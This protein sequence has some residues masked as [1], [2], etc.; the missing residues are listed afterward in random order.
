MS[1]ALIEVRVP[2]AS[3]CDYFSKIFQATQ[4]SKL[5]LRKTLHEDIP[6]RARGFTA[7]PN[8]DLARGVPL[9]YTMSQ[10]GFRF[11]R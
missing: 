3:N 7:Q 9:L 10:M 5:P 1:S 11:T 4:V 8:G 2:P 6:F